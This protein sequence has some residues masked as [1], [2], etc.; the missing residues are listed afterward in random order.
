MKKYLLNGNLLVA[1]SIVF[2]LVSLV[3]P[4]IYIDLYGDDFLSSIHGIEVLILGWIDFLSFIPAWFANITYCIAFIVYC[5]G[6][7]T[8]K[9]AIRWSHLTLGF[10]LTSYLYK[11]PPFIRREVEY[12]GYFGTGFYCWL[13]SFILLLV[14]CYCKRHSSKGESS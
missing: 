10:A 2:Y 1:L 3:L 9:L 13:L 5:Y 11:L 12:I 4:A 7:V 8:M 14:A 6:N